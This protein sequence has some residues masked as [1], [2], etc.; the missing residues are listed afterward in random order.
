MEKIYFMFLFLLF[1]INSQIKENPIYL[2]DNINPFVLSTNDNGNYYYVITKGKSLKINKESG[3]IEHSEENF[4]DHANNYFFITDKSY[5]NYI[6]NLE[7]YFQIIYNPFIEYKTVDV[8]ALPKNGENIHIKR[9]GSIAL[10]NDFVIY[11]Y[12]KDNNK[13]LFFSTKSQTYISSI[14]IKNI[15]DNL[16]CKLIENKNFICVTIIDYKL[17]IY[18]LK[19]HINPDNS[20]DDSLTFYTN[21]SS[22]HYNSV[23]GFGFYD[24]IVHNNVKFLCIKS[25]QI[26]QCRH[27]QIII[28]EDEG[29]YDYYLKGDENIKFELTNDFKEKDCYYSLLSYDLF[30]CALEDYIQCF[31]IYSYIFYTYKILIFIYI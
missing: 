13:Y 7:S 29:T 28:N 26:V 27:L 25:N 24:T 16:S 15:N 14:E 5:N 3:T 11:G 4:L 6:F 22:L 10:N 19:Y 18:C 20:I 2:I 30:C 23:S 1:G 12:S 8:S 17:D 9:V 21:S 31:R